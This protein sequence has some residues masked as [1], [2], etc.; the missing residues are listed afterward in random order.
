MNTS[1]HKRNRGFTLIELLVVIAIIAILVALLLPA[2]QQAREA[3]RRSTCKNNLKQLGLALHNY[4]DTYRV[5]PPGY[6]RGGGASN[7][8]AWGAHIL[9]FMEQGPLFEALEISNPNN[10]ADAFAGSGQLLRTT[11]LAAYRCPSDIGPDDNS[12]R[13]NTSTSNYVANLGADVADDVS[14][15]TRIEARQNA[16]GDRGG[17]FWRNSKVRFRDIVDGTSNVIG[18]GERAWE[19]NKP[20]GQ[21]L[22]RAAVWGRANDGND[23]VSGRRE[24]R[25]VAVLAV[26]GGGPNF[27]DLFGDNGA[28][29]DFRNHNQCGIT[30]S[31]LHRGG[32]QFVLMDGGV[33]FISENINN[34]VSTTAIDSTYEQLAERK[35]GQPLGEF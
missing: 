24:A 18:I 12:Q 35:D 33:R 1:H 23:M 26:T 28:A 29:N 31:S 21:A 34:N 4:H 16:N 27:T 15:A 20:Q 30:Y 10:G 11:V 17:V 5:L 14:P 25:A 9:P 22:C 3:A 19:L 6:V 32:S 8:W 13:G 2:V 7:E